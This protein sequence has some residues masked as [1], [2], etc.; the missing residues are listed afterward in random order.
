MLGMV[1]MV[2]TLNCVATLECFTDLNVPDNNACTAET[3]GEGEGSSLMADP[4]S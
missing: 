1:F 3:P 2:L 4:K